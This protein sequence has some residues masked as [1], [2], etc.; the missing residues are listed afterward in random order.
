MRVVVVVLRLTDLPRRPRLARAVLA[1]AVLV[2]SST[3]PRMRQPPT[4]PQ[5]PAAV[6][7]GLQTPAEARV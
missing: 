2:D 7:V 6:V 5:T 4:A 1:A 3:P